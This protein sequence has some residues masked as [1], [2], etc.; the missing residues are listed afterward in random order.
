LLELL[1]RSFVT[2]N[3]SSFLMDKGA[4]LHL[5]FF[6]YKNE[7]TIWDFSLCSSWDVFLK[8]SLNAN[9]RAHISCWSGKNSYAV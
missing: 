7:D 2:S 4:S 8:N 9:L 3:I 5:D 1:I 6:I